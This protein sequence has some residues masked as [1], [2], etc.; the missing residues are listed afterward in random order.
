[1][2]PHVGQFELQVAIEFHR[3]EVG[4][5]VVGF[6][7]LV[8]QACIMRVRTEADIN[9]GN[10]VPC[11]AAPEITDIDGIAAGHTRPEHERGG[12]RVRADSQHFPIPG[13]PHVSQHDPFPLHIH[14]VHDVTV[15]G[16][17]RIDEPAE[18]VK[19]DGVADWSV[20]QRNHTCTSV[21]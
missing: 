18:I 16:G 12:F 10:A 20:S 15:H 6:A 8:H 4:F 17:A 11:S 9:P 1:M 5:L 14:R 19:V 13:A 7:A 3:L 2:C 21:P